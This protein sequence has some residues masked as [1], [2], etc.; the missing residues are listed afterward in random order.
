MTMLTDLGAAGAQARRKRPNR[1]IAF[2]LEAT[3]WDR[4]EKMAAAE[5]RDPQLQARW[6]VLQ[7]LRAAEAEP[8][9]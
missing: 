6:L 1:I 3:D 9:S 2:G 7:A 8:A 4:L 5:L